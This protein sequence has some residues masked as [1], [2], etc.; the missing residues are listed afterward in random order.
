MG[1]SG[2]YANRRPVEALIKAKMDRN[3]LQYQ[4]VLAS[5][6]E[7]STDGQE[8]IPITAAAENVLYFG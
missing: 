2:R 3:K 4:R 1:E 5:Q 7:L 6:K 8:K